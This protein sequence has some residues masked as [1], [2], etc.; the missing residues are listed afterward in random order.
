MSAL[1]RRVSLDACI[2]AYSML[3]RINSQQGTPLPEER[4]VS[5]SCQTRCCSTSLC[6]R[7]QT[8]RCFLESPLSVSLKLDNQLQV[9]S[10]LVSPAQIRSVQ[11][12]S[13]SDCYISRT[14]ITLVIPLAAPGGSTVISTLSTLLVGR[15]DG[16]GVQDAERLNNVP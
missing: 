2:T 14:L 13:S 8:S 5:T 12:G 10:S 6:V 1:N 11:P 3:T 15:N 4:G 7:L 16:V 9:E